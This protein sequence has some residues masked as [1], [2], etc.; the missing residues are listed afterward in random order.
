M[1]SRCSFI[2]LEIEE[3]YEFNFVAMTSESVT[4]SPSKLSSLGS[5]LDAAC[6]LL[7]DAR[8]CF[9]MNLESLDFVTETEKKF[10]FALRIKYFTW[11]RYRL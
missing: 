9:Q 3:K 6:A 5:L 10:R 8:R 1:S 11:F 7:V 2:I 4:I